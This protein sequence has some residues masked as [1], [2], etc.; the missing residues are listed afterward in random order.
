MSSDLLD[1]F[2]EE[3]LLFQVAHIA[4]HERIRVPAAVDFLRSLGEQ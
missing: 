4:P 3:T 2:L 1:V